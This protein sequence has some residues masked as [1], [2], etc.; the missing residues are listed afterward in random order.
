MGEDLVHVDVLLGTSLVE[1]QVHEAGV[2]LLVFERYDLVGRVGLVP[3]KHNRHAVVAAVV[4]DL[5]DPALRVHKRLAVGHVVG[6]Y[7]A[8]RVP[9]IGLG[10]DAELL[11]AGRVP[12]L[13]LDAGLAHL[14]GA[15]LE[16]HAYGRDMRV[17]E[18]LLGKTLPKSNIESVQFE[19]KIK[20][21]ASYNSLPEGE[22]SCRHHCRL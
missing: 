6:D 19:Q 18:V 13:Q 8:R 21:N 22:T 3:D 2:G 11:L 15:Q 14:D 9:V 10:D 7:D 5:L 17:G 1:G 4:L 12:H 20:L 16:V